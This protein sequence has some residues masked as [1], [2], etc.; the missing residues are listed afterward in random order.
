M[1]GWCRTRSRKQS[2]LALKAL[3][4]THHAIDD[5]GR[6]ISFSDFPDDVQFYILSF[7]TPS[8]VA[9]FACTP[10]GFVLLCKSD[11]KLRHLLLSA[12]LSPSSQ[13]IT[14]KKNKGM[15]VVSHKEK[16]QS[17]SKS[18]VGAATAVGVLLGCVFALCFPNVFLSISNPAAILNRN[19]AKSIAH[20]GSSL[21][22]SPERINLLKSDFV[23]ASDK[24][25]ELEKQTHELQMGEIGGRQ[26]D[27][28]LRFSSDEVEATSPSTP[29][30]PRRSSPVG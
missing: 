1:R 10:K 28:F 19:F 27:R 9:S 6:A 8:E 2:E 16:V 3:I 29:T 30:P 13:S 7:L 4:R 11:C 14:E 25:A 12:C 18:K 26:R 5:P 15:A 21:C 22:E 23:A 20:V 17:L 24:N